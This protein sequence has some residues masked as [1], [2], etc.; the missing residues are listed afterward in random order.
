[1]WIRAFTSLLVNYVHSERPACVF[2][3]FLTCIQCWLHLFATSATGY[4][5]KNHLLCS[6]IKFSPLF[7]DFPLWGFACEIEEVAAPLYS[8]WERPEGQQSQR[9]HQRL[10]KASI[11]EDLNPCTG[12]QHPLCR[13]QASTC[14]RSF[15]NCTWSVWSLTPSLSPWLRLHCSWLNEELT[16]VRIHQPHEGSGAIPPGLG[17]DSCNGGSPQLSREWC[18]QL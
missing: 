16:F 4:K 13:T 7:G 18:S 5:E 15:R 2:K 12:A 3:V 14:F 1:M 10:H 8:R 17:I 6:C 11:K 9:S